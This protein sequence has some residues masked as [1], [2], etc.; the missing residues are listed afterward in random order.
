MLQTEISTTIPVLDELG[1]PQNFGW[2]RSPCFTYEPG[3]IRIP[4]QSVSEGDRYIL[5]SPTHLVVFELLDDGYLGYP[6]MSVV[7]LKEKKRSTQC[8]VIPFPRG[9][10]DL[11][12]DSETGSIKF[13]QKK[14]FLNFAVMD[15]GVRIIKADIP[16]FGHHY[17]LRGEVVLTP[18]DGAE[19]LV[20][21]MAWRGSGDAFCY[22]RRSPW[23][24]AEGVIQF[25][26]SELIFTR[27]NGW[28]IFD[29]TRGVRPRTDLC[30]W[31]VGC[32]QSGGHQA[33]FSVGYNSADS[34]L[35]TENAF[36]LDGK[37]HKLDQVTF[38]IPSGRHLPW[39]FTSNDNRLEMIFLLNQERD[40]SHQM[41]FYSLKRRQLFGSFSGKVILDDG[42]EF[43]FEDLS[44]MAER[45]KSRL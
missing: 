22:S 37:L 17:S 44:G 35:G 6:F 27:G 2:A 40:E 28:G 36:F 16:R 21:H 45:R 26:S 33:G 14:S 11:P 30:F 24:F 8:S 1:R 7:S 15:G 9:L 3:L 42:S 23:Y 25:G 4:R 10:F 13:R 41:F 20:T 29:W 43:E 12:K 5:L 19:S 32:G 34:S 31:A 18:P 39:R 38:H